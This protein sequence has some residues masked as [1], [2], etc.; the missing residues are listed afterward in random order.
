MPPSFLSRPLFRERLRDV[1]IA[2]WTTVQIPNELA[3]RLISIYF[4]TEYE[5]MPSVEVD[6]FVEDLA[7]GRHWF[8]SSMLVNAILAW[9]CQIY[10]PLSQAMPDLA[11][12]FYN[13]ALKLNSQMKQRN[14][15]TTVAALQVLIMASITNG[16]LDLAD[17]CT[18][19]AVKIGKQMGLFGVRYRCE[20]AHS[21]LNG[22]LEWRRAA[23]YTA[24]GT[25]NWVVLHNMHY[26]VVDIEVP[27]LLPMPGEVERL[28]GGAKDG[29]VD[30]I[31]QHAEVFDRTCE[32]RI[33]MNDIMWKYFGDPRGLPPERI[34][35]AV[36]ASLYQRLLKWAEDLPLSMARS[37][38][39]SQGIMIMHIHFH[40]LV[41]DIFRMFL[42]TPSGSET[43]SLMASPDATPQAIYTASVNQ[44]K[45]LLLIY[46]LKYKPSTLSVFWHTSAMYTANAV[47]ND[48]RTAP[49]M[50]RVGGSPE[51]HFYFDL[52]IA[53]LEDLSASYPAFCSAT[54]GVLAVALRDNAISNVKARRIARDI[55]EIEAQY[56]KINSRRTIAAGWIIDLEL[57]M[58]NPELAAGGS[59]AEQLKQLSLDD[60]SEA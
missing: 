32:L 16:Q 35:V 11:F 28:D 8:C 37:E 50:K 43:L 41:T 30:K 10:T 52:C 49:P 1:D 45:R 51:W 2:A 20:S 53:A 9:S 39:S 31:A 23:S 25:F 34:T 24:W 12:A 60:D 29:S 56:D 40:A 5:V 6:L 4:D 38:Q 42:A 21:W 48:A 58:T 7:C 57:G 18:K 27:P 47:V 14:T 19:E 59:L 26:H 15:L 33:I 44:L 54:K 22:H 36:A 46:R 55:E 13:E 3:I 17:K